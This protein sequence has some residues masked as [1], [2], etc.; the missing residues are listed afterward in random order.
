MPHETMIK[1]AQICNYKGGTAYPQ[2]LQPHAMSTCL[3]KIMDHRE[4]DDQYTIVAIETPN[5]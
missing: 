5:P 4:E 1:E 2:W 3:A